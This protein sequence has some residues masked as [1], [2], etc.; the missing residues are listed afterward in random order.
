MCLLS[1]S[2]NDSGAGPLGLALQLS[3]QFQRL[4]TLQLPALGLQLPAL[5][6][7]AAR[8]S[9]SPGVLGPQ[10]SPARQQ[11]PPPGLLKHP[12]LHGAA[13]WS[14]CPGVLRQQRSPAR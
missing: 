10:R 2:G 6:H 3:P 13:Q 4:V 11:L 9:P 1:C 12:Q 5:L 8:L 14:P 7:G